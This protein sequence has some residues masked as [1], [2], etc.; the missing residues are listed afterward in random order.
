MS[1]LSRNTKDNTIA[2]NNVNRDTNTGMLVVT[3]VRE[4]FSA[5]SQFATNDTTTVSAMATI[6]TDT[7]LSIDAFVPTDKSCSIAIILDEP[8]DWKEGRYVVSAVD[9]IRCD[10][11]SSSQMQVMLDTV[12]ANTSQV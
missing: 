12:Q 4:I 5:F 8:G 2:I 11:V 6:D 10:D 9:I 7:V 1:F 3:S